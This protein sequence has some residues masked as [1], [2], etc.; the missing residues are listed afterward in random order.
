MAVTISTNK[1]YSDYKSSSTTSLT[2][3]TGA[4]TALSLTIE[5]NKAWTAADDIALVATAA[6]IP[7]MII[8]TVTSY[9]AG[10]G[11]LVVNCTRLEST[12]PSWDLVS[13]T[14]ATIAGSGNITF[15]TYNGK[16]A[17]LGA[18]DP[19]IVARRSTQAGNRMLGTV[20]SYDNATGALVF[21]SAGSAGSGTH[22]DW[23]I[24]SAGTFTAWDVVIPPTAIYSATGTAVLTYD[25]EPKYPVGSGTALTQGKIVTNNQTNNLWVINL[26]SKN[27]NS[28]KI[29]NAEVNGELN[30]AGGRIELATGTGAAGQTI[31]LSSYTKLDFPAIEVET[32]NG[33]GVYR[34]WYIY[35]NSNV[36]KRGYVGLNWLSRGANFSFNSSSSVVTLTTASP[37]V[38]TWNAH[39]LK[40]GHR[41][42][43]TSTGSATGITMD[44]SYFVLATDFT[45]NSFKIGINIAATPINV[46]AQSG[47]HTCYALPDFGSG[48]QGNVLLYNPTTKVLT[49]GDGTNGNLIVSGAKIRMP[50]V[51]FTMEYPRTCINSAIS[52]A[53]AGN[54]VSFAVGNVTNLT[55]AGGMQLCIN[56]EEFTGTFTGSTFATATRAVNGSVAANHAQGDTCYNVL[57]TTSRGLIDLADGG[58]MITNCVAFSGI[59]WNMTGF[60]TMSITDTWICGGS[61]FGSTTADCTVNG[62]FNSAYPSL[63][64]GTLIVNGTL[65]QVDFQKIYSGTFGFNTNASPQ[66]FVSSNNQN[67]IRAEDIY[68]Y[69][70]HRNGSSTA[71]LI[72]FN[73]NGINCTPKRL[74]AIGGRILFNGSANFETQDLYIGAESNGQNLVTAPMLALYFNNCQNVVARNVNIPTGG[75]AHRT[76]FLSTDANC[77]NIIV[78]SITYDGQNNAGYI[79]QGIGN[80]IR[81][82][83]GEFGTLRDSRSSATTGAWALANSASSDSANIQNCHYV[84]SDTYAPDNGIGECPRAFIEYCSG[85]SMHWRATVGF[86]NNYQE[87]GPFHVLVDAGKTT[88]TLCYTPSVKANRDIYTLNGTAYFDNSGSLLLPINGDYC[89]IKSYQPIRTITGFSGVVDPED[90]N[91][92]NLTYEFELVN[93]DGTFATSWTALTTA[94][95]NSALSAISGYLNVKGF[96]L[97]IKITAT[98]SDATN[99]VINIRMFTTNNAS[100]NLPIGYTDYTITNLQGTCTAI[101][102]FD[103]TTEE[104]YDAC[105]A[106]SN[107]SQ[108]PYDFDGTDA[109]LSV[110]VRNLAYTWDDHTVTFDQ[111][112]LSYTSK[113]AINSE[114]TEDD[115]AVVSAYT[116]LETVEKIYDYSTYWGCL[117]ANL[118]LDRVCIK[119]GNA[120]DFGAYDL[121]FDATA[122][123]VFSKV[124][125]TITIKA[126]IVNTGSIT[127]TGT[128]TLS[129]GCVTG[130]TLLTGSNGASGLLQLLGLT[131]TAVYVKDDSDAEVDYVAS[132]TGTYSLIIPFGSTGSWAWVTKR[133]GY[134]HAV[135]NFTASDGGNFINTPSMPEKLNPDGTAMYTGS[136]SLLCD[137]SFDGTTQANI[138]IGDGVVT[139]QEAFDESE[140]ALATN[141][142]MI[143]L[144]SGKSDTSQ[145]N[146]AGGDYF[147]L[148]TG[149]RLR[150][151]SAGDV[152]ATIESFVIGADGTVVDG[153]NGSVQFLTSDS[154][155][156]IAQA[157]LVALQGTFLD[158]NIARVNGYDV[159]G[160]G[161]ETTPWGPAI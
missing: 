66:A 134:R 80:K 21:T 137:V 135:G 52:S 112:P 154:P 55:V 158:V 28:A 6:K 126:S 133:L 50:N 95:L 94:N 144:A 65:G 75:S 141:D 122:V 29:F 90:I 59:Y 22:T 129:N 106:T 56:E 161:T 150:R 33:T 89:I 125:N 47:T 142:G 138:D 13:S 37:T 103:G 111:Y 19:I 121:V 44:A 104:E 34:P 61:S 60:Q 101:G 8:G 68:A 156:A 79:T 116:D 41:L 73:I 120:L 5:L 93:Y 14:S 1:N 100:P 49:V 102:I 91:N 119:T 53:T 86:A 23:I 35:E 148:S 149:W 127:T 77:S 128:I 97:R 31:D 54:A 140:T 105:S 81:V 30:L 132:V 110:K 62:L 16:S 118:I 43:F 152:N 51:L 63:D 69:C 136:T 11:A 45:A 42:R 58:K 9:N 36:N 4:L 7:F 109:T 113:Q 78:H 160:E 32:G 87:V 96:H 92:A 159:G 123:S 20:F 108:L 40:P 130:T 10:T 85:H 99:R 2:I 25:K 71:A 18:T 57:G 153:V 15:Q 74:T 147:F 76:G 151:A 17:L 48:E 64:S 39:G 84:V 131:S 155:T 83:N 88:G 146:S 114:I 143:W 67:I 46:T 107:T 3:G 157:V 82:V 72:Y 117:R 124:G 70:T 12:I 24:V 27:T 98:V 145:F 26:G 115:D 38:V 139:L